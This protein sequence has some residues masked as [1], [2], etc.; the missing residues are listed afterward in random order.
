MTLNYASAPLNVDLGSATHQ[1][2][3]RENNED[4]YLTMRFGRSLEK[5]IYES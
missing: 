1:G 2:L 5:T 4:S 3:V